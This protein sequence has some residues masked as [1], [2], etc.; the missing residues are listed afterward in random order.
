MKLVIGFFL[1]GMGLSTIAKIM[2]KV[3]TLQFLG[4]IA[5]VLLISL[6][7]CGII[8]GYF[9]KIEIKEM[10]IPAFKFYYFETQGTFNSA[11]ANLGPFFEGTDNLLNDPDKSIKFIGLYFDHPD[12]IK[13]PAQM[14]V[15]WGYAISDPKTEEKYKDLIE[16][17]KKRN[18]SEKS[19]PAQKISYGSLK[20]HMILSFIIAIQKIYPPL[21]EHVKK[22]Y[23]AEFFNENRPPTIHIAN[24][25]SITIG[26]PLGKE[27]D[28]LKISSI[29]APPKNEKW[30]E[31]LK[32]SKP[33]TE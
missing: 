29:A 32:N 15:A 4:L 19:F 22:L 5:I 26:W 31:E 27:S 20:Y 16:L 7:F 6:L 18:A 30:N 28:A 10:Q 21:F 11:A 2:Q 17:I 9:N 13:D 12:F 1:L 3:S 8:L 24:F 14:R 25:D 33:K 23:P